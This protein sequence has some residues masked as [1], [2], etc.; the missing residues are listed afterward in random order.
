M[1]GKAIEDELRGHREAIIDAQS[2]LYNAHAKAILELK[3]EVSK[4]S[5]KFLE[6]ALTC[7]ESEIKNLKTSFINLFDQTQTVIH[8]HID[9]KHA[10][11][12][13]NHL[14]SSTTS[15]SIRPPSTVRTG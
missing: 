8:Q 3:Y 9:V 2:V 6:S 11:S 15:T 12:K 1:F 14:G 10:L 4:T 7:L 13:I 5:H